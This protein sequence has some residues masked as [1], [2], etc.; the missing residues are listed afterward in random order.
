MIQLDEALLRAGYCKESDLEQARS[1]QK[2]YGGRLGHIMLNM[3]LITE[4]QLIDSLSECLKLSRLSDIPE[5]PQLLR[6][7]KIKP[8]FLLKNNVFLLSGG[9]EETWV[10]TNDPFN[11][12][13]FSLIERIVSKPVRLYLGS[14]EELRDLRLALESELML[15]EEG[16][17]ATDL[18][19]E[20]DKL[21]ELASEAPV[22]RLVNTLLSR[23]VQ[24]RASDIHFECFKKFMK[25][26]FRVDGVMAS[27]D[28]V[29]AGV[30]LA[31]ITRLK[32]LSGMNIA[33]N[34]L[35]QDGRISIRVG[36]KQVDIRSSSVP[37]SFGESFVLRLL[38]K[39][40]IKYSLE[41]LGYLADHLSLLREIAAKPNGII[42]TT[43]PTGSGKTTTLYSVLNELVTDTTKIVTVEDPVEYELE[44]INQ[45][46][47]RP[48]IGYTFAHSL[49]SI[50]RQDPDIIMV[51]EIRD[52]ETA[53]ISIRSSLTGHLVLSTL[54]TNTALSSI[55]RL[56]DMGIEFFLLKASIIGLM[57]QRLV[58]KICP[59]CAEPMEATPEVLAAC[60]FD[61]LKTYYE[62]GDPQLKTPAGCERCNYTGYSGRMAIT[63]IIP[64]SSEVQAE[65]EEDRNFDDPN[66]LG[67]R[68]MQQDGLIKAF[69]GLVALDEV[70][71]VTTT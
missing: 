11:L 39:E 47:V 41:S 34:R 61:E 54:H 4:D 3:G 43:G 38:G 20:I 62:L 36:G 1:V 44:G 66:K 68:T 16:S 7:S 21:R 5:R 18:D 35:P 12:E 37:T 58:R 13:I 8:E 56:L 9:Q 25:V 57:G 65:F 29:S 49:R 69:K 14:E 24:S 33:E 60:R 63:E 30:K 42:L 67:C 55:T 40:D 28:H 2:E 59:Y 50:L 31:V 23:A 22:I 32:L 51:G 71:R 52:A 6:V 48:D 10:A 70:L 27:V 17:G 64:F 53:E 26:R 19:D 46:Q 15:D 45:I